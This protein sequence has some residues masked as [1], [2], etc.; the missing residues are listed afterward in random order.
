MLLVSSLCQWSYAREKPDSG[1]LFSLSWCSDGTQLAG[2]GGNG[3]V[4]FGQVIG[5]QLTWQ[6]IEVRLRVLWGCRS[7]V[8]ESDVVVVWRRRLLV[9]Q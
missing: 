6:N 4:M 7:Y 9:Q 5:R 8:A 3:A 2:G 1:S